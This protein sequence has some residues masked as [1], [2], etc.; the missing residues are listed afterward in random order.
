MSERRVAIYGGSFDPPHIGHVLAVAWALSTAEV[1]E[2]WII[3]TWEH[4]FDKAHEASFDERMAM[5]RLAFAPFKAI[6]LL[7][8]FSF[9]TDGDFCACHF[10]PPV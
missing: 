9:K 8:G 3:P 10:Q 1:D 5:C 7:D 2:A 4:A 6:E